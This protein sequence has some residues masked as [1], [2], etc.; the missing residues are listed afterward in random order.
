MKF[1]IPENVGG[2]ELRVLPN[3][4]YE[5]EVQDVF[6][7]TSST[8]NPKATIKLIVQ[9]EFTGK[10]AADFQ[11]CIG[12]TV[13]ETVSLQ[14]QALWKVNDWVK[15]ATGEGLPVGRE[16]ESLEEFGAYL[17]EVLIGSR[18]MVLTD[19]KTNEGNEM[20]VVHKAKA[21]LS[22]SKAKKGKK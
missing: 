10:K 11:T 5:M 8:N 21:I 2:G 1:K 3:D 7:G 20:T 22:A 15:G 16:F 9:S 18:W 13:L 19:T 14:P 12:E 17:K 4:T 6:V